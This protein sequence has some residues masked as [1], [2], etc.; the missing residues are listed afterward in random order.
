MEFRPYRLPGNNLKNLLQARS[1][2]DLNSLAF[3]RGPY[4]FQISDRSIPIHK[5]LFFSLSVHKTID[6]K[7]ISAV[8][9]HYL[10]KNLLNVLTNIQTYVQLTSTYF[11]RKKQFRTLLSYSYLLNCL[12][13]NGSSNWKSRKIKLNFRFKEPRE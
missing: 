1:N 4:C 9:L 3:V 8:I 2:S 10:E 12:A 5:S 7:Y 6:N 13:A 11:T